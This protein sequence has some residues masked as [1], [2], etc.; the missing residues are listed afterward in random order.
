LFVT[1]L[2]LLGLAAFT[3]EQRTKEIGIRKVLGASLQGIVLLLS[4]DFA[5]LVIVAFCIA[6]PIAWW[7]IIKFLEQF[8]YRIELP[9]WTVLAAGTVTLILAMSIVSA[10]AIRAGKQNPAKS[11]RSE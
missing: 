5:R 8:Q 9:W 4:K 2:G 11:L 3:A 6:V 1:G 10:T 7:F